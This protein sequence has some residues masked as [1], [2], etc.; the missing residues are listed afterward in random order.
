MTT[1]YT[2]GHA[3]NYRAAIAHDGKIQK[4]GR[5]HKNQKLGMDHKGSHTPKNYPGGYA[6]KT[7]EDA[8]RRIEEAQQDKGFAVFGLKA[9]WEKDTVSSSGMNL[10]CDHPDCIKVRLQRGDEH[11]A[12]EPNETITFD[13]RATA[14]KKRE[15]QG[16]NLI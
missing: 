9:D 14:Y 2:I 12:G 3:E 8:T 4:L 5:D 6:F 10:Y 7:F 15:R 13:D 16:G 11:Y 1:I